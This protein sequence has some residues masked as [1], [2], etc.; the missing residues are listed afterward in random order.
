MSA[1]DWDELAREYQGGAT[2]EDIA[3]SIGRSTQYVR[4]HLAGLVTPRPKGQRV[5][6]PQ[7]PSPVAASSSIDGHGREPDAR[8]VRPSVARMY[9]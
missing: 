6:K 7:K 8:I 9:R 1:N 5:G 3:L 4:R 2:F